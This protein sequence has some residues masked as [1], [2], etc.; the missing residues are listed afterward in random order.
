MAYRT[1]AEGIRALNVKYWGWEWK[2]FKTTLLISGIGLG[3]AGVFSVGA[4]T[5]GLY[6]LGVAFSGKGAPGLLESLAG[7][8]F[9]S[10]AMVALGLAVSVTGIV[11]GLLRSTVNKVYHGINLAKLFQSE[12][13]PMQTDIAGLLH[14]VLAASPFTMILPNSLS[15]I[16]PVGGAVAIYDYFASQKQ[17]EHTRRVSESRSHS[18]EQDLQAA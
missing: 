15:F 2:N 11:H 5:G 1:Q 14:Y 13:H 17:G 18:P 16:Y 6:T 7:L 10:G 9:G 8:S 3:V 12:A 4:A